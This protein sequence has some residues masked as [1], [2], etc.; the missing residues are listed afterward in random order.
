MIFSGTV[1][2]VTMFNTM[3]TKNNNTFLFPPLLSF[4]A[5]TLPVLRDQTVFL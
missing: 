2:Q 4:L 5:N 3:E 1:Q